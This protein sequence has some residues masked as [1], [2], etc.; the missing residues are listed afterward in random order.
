[1]RMHATAALAAMLALS[2]AVPALGAVRFV[3]P[4]GSDA[5][6]DC[7]ASGTPCRTIVRGLAAAV[8]GDTIEVAG[9]TYAET[10]TFAPMTVTLSGGWTPN[11][12]S[13]DPA[14]N[15]TTVTND[16]FDSF[17]LQGQTGE[18]YDVTLD[19]FSIV[20]NGHSEAAGIEVWASSDSSVTFAINATHFVGTN[21]VA[22][23]GV[24]SGTLGATMTNCTI[25]KTRFANAVVVTSRNTS[26]VTVDLDGCTIAKNKSSGVFLYSD[27]AASLAFSLDGSDVAHNANCG[28]KAVSGPNASLE[29][30]IDHSIVEHNKTS[31]TGA[32]IDV[33]GP[34]SAGTGT[35]AIDVTGSTIANNVARVDGGGVFAESDSN[36]GCTLDLTNSIVTRNKTLT[37]GGGIA[38]TARGYGAGAVTVD[39]TNSTVT[40]NRSSAG[41]GGV[42]LAT[43]TQFNGNA[44]TAN[45]LNTI[46][47]NNRAPHS[48]V[49]GGMDL[50]LSQPTGTVEANTDHDDI[51]DV[52]V[53]SGTVNDLG[54]NIDA[55]PLF[56][57][58][59]NLHLQSGSPCIDSGTCA[60][61]PTTDIDGDPRPTGP[62][63]DIGADEFV[64]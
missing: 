55:N 32:G 12:A 61:A 15:V 9:G 10:V 13:R 39:L 5:A 51:G 2:V 8:S 35:I 44:V 49:T 58:A 3:S 31:G 4:A 41:G 20:G 30:T 17:A 53:L 60:G 16:G 23:V 18:T 40:R 43:E 62:G 25:T 52:L 1:M 14:A 45:L 19:G 42:S 21:G 48:S 22:F 36:A 50:R 38:A 54:G 29:A 46:L 33:Y 37:V 59:K 56:M 7:L 6:N 11:F 64:P 24:G 27:E 57:S 34:T 26:S 47:F 63:C 28:V